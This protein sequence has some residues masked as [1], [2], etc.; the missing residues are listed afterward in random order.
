MSLLD[1]F[2]AAWRTDVTVT[3]PVHRTPD[4]YLAAPGT[5]VA[6]RGCLVAPGA[7]TAPGLTEP[8]T[9]EAPETSATLY[10]PPGAP[11]HHRDT[12]TI[13]PSHTLAGAWAVEAPPAPWP[14]GLVVALIRR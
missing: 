2:P 14:L 4:G 8:A 13:P 7:S 11:I 10:A 1:G 12:V 5:P 6:V 9:S 3:G